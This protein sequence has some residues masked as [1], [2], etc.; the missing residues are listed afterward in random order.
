MF[1]IRHEHKY[2]RTIFRFLFAIVEGLLQQSSH[3][4]CVHRQALNTYSRKST[5]D[6]STAPLMQVREPGTVYFGILE[7]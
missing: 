6:E 7:L 4:S 3:L 1:F 5:R 2:A